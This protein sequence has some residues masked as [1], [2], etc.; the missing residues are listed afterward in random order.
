MK[1]IDESKKSLVQIA[2]SNKHN[3]T[4]EASQSLKIW[5]IANTT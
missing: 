5:N 2:Q 4:Q 3:T 1:Q